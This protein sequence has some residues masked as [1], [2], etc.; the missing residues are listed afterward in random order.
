MTDRPTVFIVDDDAAVRE[1]L[2]RL[3]RSAGY[4]VE[5]FETAGAF[6]ETWRDGRP[7]CLVTDIRMPGMSGLELQE[8]M[9]AE[10]SSIPTI[11]LTGFG[12]VPGAV[13]ALKGGALDF[14]QKPFEPDVLLVRIAEALKK[15]ARVREASARAAEV[16][17]RLTKLTPREREVMA[18]VIDGKANKVIALELGISE[19]TVE[20]HRGRVMRKV[21]ARSVA[22]LIRQVQ[23]RAD[24]AERD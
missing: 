8:R 6:L 1:G 21:G 4:P 5:C 16:R 10:G 3:V 20:L 24:A 13:R 7:G 11:I 23:A 12:D 22:Q 2:S 9:R 17:S 19:R 14:L 18:H 15:D